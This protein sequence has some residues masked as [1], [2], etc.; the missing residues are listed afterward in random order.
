MRKVLNKIKDLLTHIRIRAKLIL[1]GC[2]LVVIPIVVIGIVFSERVSEVILRQ[3]EKD[4]ENQVYRLSE[5]LGNSIKLVE[6]LSDLIYLNESLQRDLANGFDTIGDSAVVYTN[7]I[8]P[9]L[10]QNRILHSSLINSIS[11]YIEHHRFLVN[12]EEIIYADANVKNQPWYQYLASSQGNG[13]KIWNETPYISNLGYKSY[14][15]L[16]R[17]L[18]RSGKLAG[19]LQIT[20]QDDYFLSQLSDNQTERKNYI[21]DSYG[22]IVSSN[23]SKSIGQDAKTFSALFSFVNDDSGINEYN[24]NGEKLKVVY[25]SF[26]SSTIAKDNWMIVSV[27][28]ET[29]LLYQITEARNIILILCGGIFLILV[30]F[31]TILS[32]SITQRIDNVAQGTRR[33]VDGNYNSLI[34]VKGNDEISDLSK[35]FNDMMSHLNTLVNEVVQNKIKM[36]NYKIKQQETEFI[37][38]Q[39]QINPHFLY[40]TLDAIRMHAVLTDNDAIATMLVSLSNLLRYNISRGTEYIF[41]KEEINH[42]KNYIALMN[43]RYENSIT[44]E[45]DIPKDIENVMVLKLILQPIVENSLKHGFRKNQ[46]ESII[47][48]TAFINDETIVINIWDN[49]VGMDEITLAKLNQTLSTQS[50]FETTKSIGLVNVSTRIKLCFGSE[51]GLEATSIVNEMTLIKIT[52]PYNKGDK[53]SNL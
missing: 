53:D 26:A 20:L 43:V 30:A 50:E 9:I 45:T 35:N 34:E 16:Y 7:V 51:Y 5:D 18:N 47:K 49:G 21:I 38:L 28:P 48:I 14:F 3:N 42:V 33:V 41:L 23:V 19:I 1:V 29:F 27:V 40:N 8:Y 31:I 11:I 39:N 10:R 12:G 44:L 15:T 36:Q 37:S 25:K 24:E 32:K 4:M 13:K 2:I 46:T 17:Q 6:D 22:K 52:I